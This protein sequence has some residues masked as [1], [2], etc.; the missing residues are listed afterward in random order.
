MKRITF[1]YRPN[2]SE[3]GKTGDMYRCVWIVNSTQFKPNEFY[4][5]KEVTHL[6]RNPAWDVSIKAEDA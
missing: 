4:S 2:S 6:C 3:A 1:E 5:E